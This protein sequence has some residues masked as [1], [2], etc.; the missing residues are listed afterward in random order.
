VSVV[1]PCYNYGRYLPAAVDSALRQSGV[2]VEVLIVDDR[3]TDDSR[4]VAARLVA[5]HPEVQL[6]ANE[7]NCGHVRSFNAG[8]ERSRGEFVVK[9]DADDLLAPGALER[10]AALFDARPSVGL[11]YGHPHHFAGDVPPPA[12][13]ARV[14]WSIWSGRDWLAER[15]RLG[16]SAIT[17]PEMVLRS[18]LLRQYGP[19][20]PSVPFAPDME[21]SLRLAA[22]SDVGR[23]DGAD[24]ALHREHA[25]SMSETDGSGVLVD[26]EAR[27]QAFTRA[28]VNAAARSREDA[29][30]QRRARRALA[31][32]AVRLASAT[33]D[34]GGASPRARELL[35]F[36]Q[37]T[38]PSAR[39]RRAAR[40]VQSAGRRSAFGRVARL[41]RRL[42][43]R[44]RS[45][46]YYARWL[47]RGI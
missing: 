47:A 44:V 12:R 33:A 34:R 6:I 42:A 22:V 31:Q 36:A 39:T 18:R 3:S 38:D 45:E 26:L 5:A 13:L 35:D 25:A 17:N 9:L 46:R 15:C 43:R 40:R 8:F 7:E 19:M 4:D 2:D 11:V 27:S 21:L 10:A 24:Q 16:V 1:I 29:D 23:V 28:F 30:L 20:D 14:R 37:R 32:D 41:A